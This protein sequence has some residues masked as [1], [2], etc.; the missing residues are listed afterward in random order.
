MPASTGTVYVDTSFRGERGNV[1]VFGRILV[2]NNAVLGAPDFGLRTIKSIAFSP[3]I[4]E[5][6]Q[7]A[8]LV[9]GSLGSLTGKNYK[10]KLV[11][12]SGSIGSRGFLGSGNYVR[13][14]T[15]VLQNAGS[16]TGPTGGLGVKVTIGTQA[17]SVRANYTAVGE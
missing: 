3:Q 1:L 15:Y 5:S 17:G 8:T 4:S 16:V 7:S 14:R 2:G 12:M 6:A 11:T 9:A 10:R 13:V